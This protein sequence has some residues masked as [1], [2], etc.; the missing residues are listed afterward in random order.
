MKSR[1]E[2]LKDGNWLLHSQDKR[3]KCKEKARSI[4]QKKY[5]YSDR[6]IER[7]ELYDCKCPKCGRIHQA[8]FVNKPIVMP[9]IYCAGCAH[10]RGMF[11]TAAAVYQ[12][13][14]RP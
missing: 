4:K 10:C 1:V 11:D 14:S 6:T 13:S 8:K 9:R 5:L 3:K 12:V 7:G 2:I